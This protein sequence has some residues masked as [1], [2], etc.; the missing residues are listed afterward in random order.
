M[1]DDLSEIEALLE[2]VGR[3]C[4]RAIVSGELTPKQTKALA[5]WMFG[6][7]NQRFTLRRRVQERGRGELKKLMQFM[8]SAS[9]LLLE[10][11]ENKPEGN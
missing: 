9:R 6:C 1:S 11:G 4:L 2:K 7:M 10:I 5:K 8:A 3:D